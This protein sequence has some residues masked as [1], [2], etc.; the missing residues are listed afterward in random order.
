MG[1]AEALA[2]RLFG[3]IGVNADDHIGADQARAL[4]DI[5]ADA[6]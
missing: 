1:H 4:D 5:E 6:A 2:E 3:W